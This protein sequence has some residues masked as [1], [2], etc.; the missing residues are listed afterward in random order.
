LL[1]AVP[2]PLLASAQKLLK[3]RVVLLK[4]RVVRET[5]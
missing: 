1:R 2:Q 4:L 3:P 5:T